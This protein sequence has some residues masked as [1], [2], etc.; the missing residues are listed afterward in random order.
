MNNLI[1]T[2]KRLILILVFG[3]QSQAV[4]ADAG[5]PTAEKDLKSGYDNEVGFGGKGAINVQ[6]EEEDEVKYPV[7]RWDGIDD[8]LKPW[9]QDPLPQESICS[10]RAIHWDP[11]RVHGQGE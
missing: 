4:L 10:I 6:L 7:F 2:L 9:S 8:W 11:C 3:A 1:D 5:T